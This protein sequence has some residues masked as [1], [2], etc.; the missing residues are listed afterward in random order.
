M[1]SVLM[2]VA[3]PL[4]PTLWRT[5]RAIAN[6][7]RLQIFSFLL[8]HPGQNV[9]AIAERLRKPLPL[10]SQYLRVLEAR[11]LLQARRAGRKVEYRLRSANGDIGSRMAEALRSTFQGKSE[12]V[13]TVFRLATAFTHPRRIEIFRAIHVQPRT[14]AQLQTTTHISSWALRRHLRKLQARRFV[15]CSEGFYFAVGRTD[16]LGRELA[17][18][19]S[20]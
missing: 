5:C 3:I 7:A 2:S 1:Q 10:A 18:L 8:R 14:L 9:S 11:G 6:R 15:A 20:K 4:Q 19:A 13:E 12:P 17:R 16:D